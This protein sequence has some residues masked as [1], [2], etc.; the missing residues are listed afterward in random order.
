MVINGNLKFHTGG[1]GELQQ[2]LMQRFTTVA[3]DA[4]LGGAELYT[5]RLIYNT[6]TNELNWYDGTAWRAFAG[7]GVGALQFEVDAIETASGGIFDTDGTYVGSVLDAG[8]NITASTNL[9]NAILQLDTAI[10][11]AAGVDT[12]PELTDVDS[13][14]NT[15]IADGDLLRYDSVNSQ[16]EKSGFTALATNDLMQ[17][18]GTNWVNVTPSTIGG[19]SYGAV[20]ADSGSIAAANTSDTFEIKTATNGGIVTAAT[21]PGTDLIT[22][23]MSV[24]GLAAGTTLVL[25]DEIAVNDGGS[26]LRYTFTDMVQDLDIPNAISAN[27]LVT[28]TAADTYASRSITVDGAG[29]LDGLAVTNGNGVAGDPTIGLDINGN[30]AVST[31]VAEVTTIDCAVSSG[32]VTGDYFTLDSPTTS[33]YV[34]FNV[35]SGGGDPAPAG[36]TAIQVNV[37]SNTNTVVAA[38]ASAAINGFGDF[39]TAD[40]LP[41]VGFTDFIVTNAAVGAVTD[42]ADVNT[43]LT[44]TVNTQGVDAGIASG[45]KFIAYDIDGLANVSVTLADINNAVISDGIAL[46]DLSDVV[47]TAAANADVLM[48]NGTSWVDTAP[49]AARTSLDVYSKTESD[50]NFVDV[51]G[52]TM[53]GTLAMGTNVITIT[54]APVADTQVANKAYVD[55]LVN[56]LSWK[57]PAEVATTAN[58]SL[59]GEQTIDGILTSTSRILVKDQTAPA[60][61]GIYV[62]A[63][64]AWTRATDMDAAAEFTNAT[65]FVNTGTTQADTSWTQVNTVATVD[66]DAVSFVQQNG[67]SGVV[68]GAGLG[69]TGNTLNVNMGAG[70][71]ELP[72]DEVGLDFHTGGGIYTSATVGGVD[73]TTTNAQVGIRIDGTTLSLSS[74]GIKVPLSGITETEIASTA[75]GNGI[76]GG[77]GTVLSLDL[78]AGSGLAFTGIE[79]DLVSVPNSALANS[80]IT[81]AADSGVAEVVSLGQTLTVAGGTNIASVVSAT[82]TVTLNWSAALTDLSDVIITAAATND[83]IQFNGTN[84]V[85]V[86]PATLVSTVNT[87]DL[88]DITAGG[89]ASGQVLVTGTTPF[90][91]TPSQIHFVHDHTTS[92]TSWTVTHNLGQKFVNVTVYDSTDNVIIPQTIVATSTTVTTITFNTAITGTAVI[93]GVAGAASETV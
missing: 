4:L 37:A 15:G 80:S 24:A 19:N 42:A 66:T 75:L 14:L 47:I 88:A 6:T 32:I 16:W 27:G 35:A 21:S 2:A 70:I 52:D 72:S 34:W 53:T 63:A 41:P 38:A 76:Q 82:D 59:T 11:G 20:N 62:T 7:I 56:G 45:D 67:A 85:D 69:K 10:S 83:V 23:A 91:Y 50:T 29:A 49:A 51:T 61:N 73:D 25:A 64:G 8:T 65:I 90:N 87:E 58:V 74:A 5:G 55:S 44:I 79:L 40:G 33:Y 28:R 89:T 78:V 18:N 9:A 46:N 68:A 54:N 12:L 36:K 39:N 43:G 1:S 57:N 3:R 60:E 93:T 86:T 81:L 31:G 77:S 30:V 22:I 17:W 26:T 48:H 84:W 92:A 13:A 71:I